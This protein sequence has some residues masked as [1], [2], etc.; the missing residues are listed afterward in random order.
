AGKAI[1]SPSGDQ[2]GPGWNKK[3]LASLIVARTRS[4]APSIVAIFKSI[5][6]LGCRQCSYTKRFPSGE[7]LTGESISET[8]LRDGPPSV[9]IEYKYLKNGSFSS[10]RTT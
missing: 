10:D 1:V 5:S 3:P 8:S 9:A 7:K 6:F 2:L 4:S